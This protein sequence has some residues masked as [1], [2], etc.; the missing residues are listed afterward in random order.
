M[1]IENLSADNLVDPDDLNMSCEV[2]NVDLGKDVRYV[3]TENIRK[4]DWN[5]PDMPSLQVVDCL[6]QFYFCSVEHALA[7]VIDYLS[8][9]VSNL[10]MSEV[11]PMDKCVICGAEFSTQEWHLA[12][13]LTVERGS[14]DAVE[15]IS[16]AHMAGFCP[17]CV[18]PGQ[19]IEALDKI[20]VTYD[21]VSNV[22]SN[23]NTV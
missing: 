6:S 13:T 22:V 8:E 3:V 10:Q 11:K 9:H 19:D 20:V 4:V 18:P 15:F 17:C 14:R 16:G 12:L 2:C 23:N 7:Y 21:S 5:E 1:P